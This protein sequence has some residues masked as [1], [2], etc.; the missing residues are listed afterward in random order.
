MSVTRP[1]TGAAAP[2]GELWTFEKFEVGALI[3][4]SL[5]RVDD[6]FIKSWGSIYGV[7]DRNG[8]LPYGA[9]QLLIMKAYAEVVQP[10]PPGNIHATQKC[11]LNSVPVLGRET[12]VSVSCT[13]KYIRGNRKVVDFGVEISDAE[14]GLLYAA[15]T[16]EICWA[17]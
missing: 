17:V 12:K 4:S 15:S 7:I 16:L 14:S 9:A 10:R 2:N 5:Q 6:E 1:D 11:R 8:S 3:G 13:A